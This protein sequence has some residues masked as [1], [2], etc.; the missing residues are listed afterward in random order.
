MSANNVTSIES[1]LESIDSK[2][3]ILL[4]QISSIDVYFSTWLDR[5][6]STAEQNINGARF[7]LIEQLKR[8]ER[9]VL[10]KLDLNWARFTPSTL[11]INETNLFNYDEINR[12][13]NFQNLVDFVRFFDLHP[14]RLNEIN[15]FDPERFTINFASIL[16]VRKIFIDLNCF[17]EEV[18]SPC[19]KHWTQ[20]KLILQIM[21]TCFAN[22]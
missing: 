1:L 3:A 18:R 5:I 13:G 11:I 6:D 12:A 7:E 4:N 17:R 15:F 22:V 8:N 9:R 14:L 10:E 2:R 21:N 20:T 16:T 19:S